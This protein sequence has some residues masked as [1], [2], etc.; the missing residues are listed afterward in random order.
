M[1]KTISQLHFASSVELTVVLQSSLE[2]C[3]RWCKTFAFQC[4]GQQ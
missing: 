1:S 2:A 3:G 4:C